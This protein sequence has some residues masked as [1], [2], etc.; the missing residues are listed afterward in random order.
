MGET[1]FGIILFLVFT[2]FIISEILKY[3]NNKWRDQ[4]IP[5]MLKD[6][7]TQEK[8]LQF[9]DYKKEIYRFSILISVFSF[10]GTLIMLFGGFAILDSW[11]RE[12]TTHRILISIIYFAVLGLVSDILMTPFD[13]YETFV[14]EEKYGF[15]KSTVRTYIFDKLKSWLLALLIGFPLSYLIIWLY[16][17][18]GQNFW[19]MVWVVISIFS[20]GMTFLYSNLIVPLFNKQTPLQEGTLKEKIK[21]LSERVGFKLSNIYVIDGSKRSTRANAYFTGFGSRKRIVLYDTLINTHSEEEIVAVLAHEIGHYKKKHVIK[22]MITSIVNTGFLLFIFSLI[23]DNPLIYNALGTQPGFHIGV[24][25]FGIL[26][27]PVSFLFSLWQNAVSRKY[28][29]EADD[30]AAVNA[31]AVNLGKALKSLT[32][33][34]LSDL[35]PHPWYVKAYYSHPPL[36]NRIQNLIKKQPIEAV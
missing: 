26:F 3:Y 27:T 8:Y 12:I 5:D 33:N 6:V 18:F 13:V 31:S 17:Q 25:V 29:F 11:V 15:N 36:L 9:R 7:Y 4:P 1:L 30:F 19:W 35:T 23:I 34:N 22:G 28:E 16:Y 10:L 32:A 2:N 14:I 21:E 24:I 20:L